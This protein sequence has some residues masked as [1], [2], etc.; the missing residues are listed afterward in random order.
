M[1]VGDGPLA[2]DLSAPRV[3]PGSS[4]MPLNGC[5]CPRSSG[6][7]PTPFILPTGVCWAPALVGSGCLQDRGRGGGL[8]RPVRGADMPGRGRVSPLV[9]CPVPPESSHLIAPNPAMRAASVQMGNPRPGVVSG[10]ARRR[11]S[12]G[13]LGLPRREA[14]LPRGCLRRVPRAHFS[15]FFCFPRGGGLCSLPPPAPGSPAP[16]LPGPAV[17]FGAA[18]HLLTSHP[19]DTGLLLGWVCF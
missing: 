1:K 19:V 4:E 15:A 5:L 6:P 10:L 2:W 12:S 14:G 16:P 9:M 17:Q 3:V 8:Q 13:S 18:Q 7:V 11:S